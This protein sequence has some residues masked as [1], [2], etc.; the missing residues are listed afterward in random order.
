[1][2]RRTDARSYAFSPTKAMQGFDDNGGELPLRV[3]SDPQFLQI[4]VDLIFS[5]AAVKVWKKRKFFSSTPR[6]GFEHRQRGEF[7]QGYYSE[8][9]HEP[10]KQ[11]S[12]QFTHLDLEA[13][14][15][16]C[17]D[18]ATRLYGPDEDQV[19]FASLTKFSDQI[20]K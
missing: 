14:E 17:E 9:E 10:N 12:Q 3:F 11:G 1:M 18:A 19:N 8:G 4:D 15:V 2:S 6:P 7:G 20:L 13:F 16:A 5:A